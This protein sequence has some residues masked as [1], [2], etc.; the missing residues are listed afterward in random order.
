MI[1]LRVNEILKEQG[2]TTYWL[3]R[4]MDVSNYKRFKQLIDNEHNSIKF[5]TIEKLCDI[6]NCEI[7]DLFETEK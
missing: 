7:N 6:L 4:Q 3:Y 5:D 2:H 1:K